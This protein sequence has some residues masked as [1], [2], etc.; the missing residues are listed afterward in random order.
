[1]FKRKNREKEKPVE[2]CECKRCHRAF[3]CECA[4]RCHESMNRGCFCACSSCCSPCTCDCRV[5]HE[6][7]CAN[8]RK[9]CERLAEAST[10]LDHAHGQVV[11]CVGCLEHEVRYMKEHE[12]GDGADR[13]SQNVERVRQRLYEFEKALEGYVAAKRALL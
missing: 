13:V 4:L 5:D 1:M 10:K 2:A 11:A 3:N 9:A 12:A 6:S 8:K 7:L